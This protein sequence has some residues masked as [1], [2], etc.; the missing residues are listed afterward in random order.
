MD[1]SGVHA[2]RLDSPY[3][4]LFTVVNFLSASDCKTIIETIDNQLVPS[5]VVGQQLSPT[6]TSQTSYLTFSD[7]ALSST[8]DQ[9]ISILL[10]VDSKLSEPIQ[11]QRYEQGQFYGAHYDWFDPKDEKGQLELSAGGQRTWTFMIYLNDVV[12]G[13]ETRFDK[14]GLQFQPSTGLALCWRNLLATGEPNQNALHSALPVLEG[15]KYIITKW[16]REKPGRN[17]N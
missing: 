2:Q 11:G 3:I 12:K 13:G 4:R 15:T 5:P 6:R 10:G 14:L 1:I 7:P 8:L 9:R 16:F 17:T